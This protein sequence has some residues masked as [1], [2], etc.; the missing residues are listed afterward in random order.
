VRYYD[1]PGAPLAD[2]L[3][4][5]TSGKVTEPYSGIVALESID[6]AGG[7]IASPIDLVR[8]FTMLDGLGEPAVLTPESIQTMVTP[9]FTVLEAGEPFYV[10]LGLGMNSTGPDATWAHGGG[11]FGTVAFAAR[12]GHG[13]AFAATFNSAPYDTLYSTAG[14]PAFDAALQKI[15]SVDA[16]KSVSW[17]EGDLFPQYLPSG[18]P[19]VFTGEIVDAANLQAGAVAPGELITIFGSFLGPRDGAIVAPSPDGFFPLDFSGT[20][21]LMN[22]AAAPLLFVSGSQINAVVPFSIDPT[23]PVNLKVRAFGYES[24]PV[25]SPV[26]ASVPAIFTADGSGTGQAA[27]FNQDGTPNS[28]MNPA[29]AGSVVSVFATGFGDTLPS[30][31]DGQV[32]GSTPP[33]VA[34]PVHITVGGQEA[35]VSAANASGF[36]AGVVQIRIQVPTGVQSGPAAVAATVRGFT[37][38]AV[39]TIAIQ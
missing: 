31:T 2:S 28:A 30:S 26:A 37:T 5:G 21:V 4:P 14:A 19:T 17:P 16:M 32:T 12:L 7:W 25:A 10:G 1:Y 34:A 15:F 11:T 36:V 35:V 9:V 23:N 6:S 38:T 39:V 8:I 3:M 29:A 22:G 18:R 20:Q 27:A 24:E 33:N 13:W